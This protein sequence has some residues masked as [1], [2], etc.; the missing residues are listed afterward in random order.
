VRT[1]IVIIF[2]NLNSLL[3]FRAEKPEGVSYSHSEVMRVVVPGSPLQQHRF[4]A[5]QRV[6]QSNN[7]ACPKSTRGYE[8]IFPSY[9]ALLS[10]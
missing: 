8:A 4:H 3:S 6:R 5:L 2:A 1:G 7:A 10:S 9:Q